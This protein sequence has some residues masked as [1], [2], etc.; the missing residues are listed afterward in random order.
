VTPTVSQSP[1]T[2][3]VSPETDSAGNKLNTKSSDFADCELI[4]SLE[5]EYAYDEDEVRSASGQNYDFRLFRDEL[6]LVQ[7]PKQKP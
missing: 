1:S 3:S 7:I 5:S 2:L 6:E 4:S